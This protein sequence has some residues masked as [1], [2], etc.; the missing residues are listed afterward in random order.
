MKQ[1][2]ERL[3]EECPGGISEY[4]DSSGWLD[5]VTD[6]DRAA[7]YQRLTDRF[8]HFLQQIH[9]ELGPPHQ[10][11]ESHELAIQAWYPEAIRAACWL[12]DDK[13]MCLALEHHDKETPI[14]VVMLCLTLGEIKDLSE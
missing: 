13:V 8:F 9:Q 7:L 2:I 5:E 11:T 3:F 4:L 12:R 6:S 14:A 1:L 10:D